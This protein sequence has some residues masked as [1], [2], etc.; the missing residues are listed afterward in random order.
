MCRMKG[1]VYA[2]AGLLKNS[3]ECIS[4]DTLFHY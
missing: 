2:T 4:V 3:A 1:V